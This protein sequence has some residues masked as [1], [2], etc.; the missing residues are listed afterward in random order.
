VS[1]IAV[2]GFWGSACQL[3]S[4]VG[5]AAYSGVSQCVLKGLKTLMRTGFP[6][7]ILYSRS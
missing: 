5:N 3:S 4:H 2:S 7:R 6:F 1:G